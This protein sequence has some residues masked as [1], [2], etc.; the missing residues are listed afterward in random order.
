MDTEH[1]AP[2][3]M[4]TTTKPQLKQS[5]RANGTSGTKR[6]HA[7]AS[8]SIN[9]ESRKPAKEERRAEKRL[10]KLQ[11]DRSH[12]ENENKNGVVNEDSTSTAGQKAEKRDKR[13]LRDQKRA[14][15]AQKAAEPSEERTKCI[16]N[17]GTVE[18][19]PHD[20]SEVNTA[21]EMRRSEKAQRRAERRAQTKARAN[22]LPNHREQ[23]PNGAEKSSKQSARPAE[24]RS[25]QLGYAED[26]SLSAVPH[27]D[28]DSFLHTNHIRIIDSST[29][30]R[31]S[32][33]PIIDFAYLPHDARGSNVG[34]SPFASFKSPT[35]IQAAAWPHLLSGRDVIGVAETGSGKTL[36][37]GVPCIRRV[38][39]LRASPERS[40]TRA[41]IVSPTRELAAQIFTQLEVLAGPASL[42][43]VCIYGGVPKDSQREALKGA[44]IIV[45]TPGRLNDFIEEGATDLSHVKYL[46][47]DEADRMLDKG[48]EDAIRSIISKT[49]SSTSARQTCMFTATWP[50]SV[51]DLA[52]TFMTQPIHITIGANNPTGEL[53]ANRAIKQV[54]E[55]MDPASKEGRLR[56]LIKQHSVKTPSNS[57]SSPASKN[58][59]LVFCL[60]KKEAARVETMLRKTLGSY[61]QIAGIHGDMSQHLRTA[62]LDAFKSGA[63]TILVATDV[64]AR[65][66]DIPDVKVVI[67]VTFPLTV[68]DYVHRIGRTGRAGAKG[69]AVTFFTEHDKALAGG[70]VNVLKAA[71]QVVPQDLLRFGTTVKK[72]AHEAYG[73]F[74]R[75]L[76][77]G[78]KKEGTMIRF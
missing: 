78:E 27:A 1:I 57:N 67:N 42:K 36:A 30:N 23:S 77:E 10:R 16:A 59:I 56:E 61:V 53:R 12:T 39:A 17:G 28:V 9:D 34:Q 65:G 3:R 25:V 26:P 46:V 50:P 71:G 64:A 52:A 31:P 74:Y 63:A 18:N 24:N 47:L 6:K 35:P 58:R 32:C 54:V 33:R 21:K 38:A 14:V 8:D 37:F 75:E 76:K 68:E 2:R 51:R 55:V 73:N 45:A 29:Q 22:E 19:G 72:K 43:T 15:R 4:T 49:P 69:L 40:P 5:L 11:K 70:L 20:D 7:D 62:S 60:Y 41:V 13:R 48:F 44:N 66:L